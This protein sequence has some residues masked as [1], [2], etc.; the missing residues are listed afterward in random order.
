MGHRSGDAPRVQDATAV[1]FH[2]RLI[3]FI[4]YDRQNGVHCVD[5]A[6]QCLGRFNSEHSAATALFYRATGARCEG[7]SA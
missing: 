2:D 7:D 5:A 6:G 1:S 3:G 4:V